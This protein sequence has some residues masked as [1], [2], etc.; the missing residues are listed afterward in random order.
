MSD[1]SVAV[2]ARKLAEAMMIRART[3][4][5]D[6]QKLVLDLQTQLCIAV[7]EKE[8]DERNKAEQRDG[9]D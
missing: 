8:Q 2:I 7:R 6:D 9:E 3:R 5:A 1:K 4:L